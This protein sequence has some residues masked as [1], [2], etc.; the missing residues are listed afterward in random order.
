MSLDQKRLKVLL[1]DND[2]FSDYTTYLARGLSEYV[3][4]VLYCFSRESP[5]ITGAVNQKGIE[6]IY[7][8]KRFPK[9]YSS[10]KGIFRVLI[11][12]FILF[13][14]LLRRK[15]DIV[16]I[17]DYL[18]A[19]FLFIPLLKL[20]R[21]RIC[22]TI[23][24]LDIFC[25]WD[26]LFAAGLNGRLQILF[27]KLV[28]QPK[29]TGICVDRIF[30]HSLSHKQKLLMKKIEEEK[31]NVI[32]QL[33][34]R[35]LLE[36]SKNN[37]RNVDLELKENCILFFG[38]IAP[39]KGIETLVEAAR[40]VKNKMG[41]VFNLVIAG[42]AY[43]G[44]DGRDFFEDINKEDLEFI[45]IINR[46]ITSYEIPLLF[47][48]SSFLVLPYYNQFEYSSSG[49]IPL[50]YTFGK[51]VIISNI[52]SL[53]EYVQHG[54]TGLIFEEKDSTQLANFMIELIENNSKTL[55]MG[56]L[57]YHKLVTEMTLD[58]TCTDIHEI[59]KSFIK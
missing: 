41:P 25:L 32:K 51:P 49:V 1:F 50:S 16:H 36:I 19:F 17:Q 37:H 14:A 53:A 27:R 47:R 24:D 15:Y 2:D 35:Y 8:D 56:Q 34:Y 29:F 18:P 59:Y 52:P 6:F 10:I 57:A 20:R 40:I 4:V 42:K 43:P 45:N 46:Y 39:W 13:D 54:K 38:N 44:F 23:H 21:K 12:F 5:K 48:K 3:D 26:R 7:I 22:W 31:I 9:G 33:D 58:K 11:L 28:T 30:V 55:E